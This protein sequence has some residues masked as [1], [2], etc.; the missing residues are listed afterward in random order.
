MSL[1]NKALGRRRDLPQIE[2]AAYAALAAGSAADP[3]QDTVIAAVPQ[4]I[5]SFL[6]GSFGQ[7]LAG[8]LPVNRM[9]PRVVSF[10]SQGS[11]NTVGNATNNCELRVNAWRAG[12]L[13]GH[14]AF[15]SLAVNTT[16]TPAITATGVQTVAVASAANIFAGSALL[17]DS[18]GSAELV[19][20]QTVSGSN[21]TANFTKTHSGGVAAT[22]A[23]MPFR[24]VDFIIVSGANTTSS[25]AVGGAGS[26]TITPASMHGIFV[27]ESLAISGGTGTAETVVVTAV[28]NTT[29]T[30]TFAGAHSGTY[31]IASASYA[32]PFELQEGDVLSLQRISNNV[33]G[34]ATPVGLIQVEWVP[35]KLL[36]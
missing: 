9:A 24:P 14:V 15:C 12:V 21:I 8:S 20:V 28:T 6:P 29:F 31:N 17:V 22:S 4:L 26:A 19:Y 18:G 10:I 30:A 11:A 32:G 35:S 27:G 7:G 25:T 13:Q 16:I 2:S 23:L 36:G 3:A 33:T 5:H 1:V 34:L